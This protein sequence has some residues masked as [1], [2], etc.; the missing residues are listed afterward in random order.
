MY[1]VVDIAGQQF[2]VE[3]NKFVYVNRLAG[4]EGSEVSFDKV[5]LVDEDGKVKVGKPLLSGAKVSARILSHL[6]ADKVL[7]F[8]KKRRKS[9]KKLNGHRQPLTKIKIEEITV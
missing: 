7:I 5:L 8:K 4:E 3:K 2:K 6:K 9:Y 1:A